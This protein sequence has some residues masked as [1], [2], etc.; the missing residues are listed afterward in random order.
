VIHVHQISKQYGSKVLFESAEAHIGHR[1]RV[2]LIGPNGAGKSTFIRILLGLESPDS[3]SVSRATH[4]AIGHLA[5]EVPKFSN[6]TVLAEVMRMDGR[7]EELLQA[8]QE[9]EAEFAKSESSGSEASGNGVSPDR[10]ERYGRV[11]EELELLDEYRLE[12]RAKEILLGMGFKLSDMDRSLTE[13][14]GG[15]LMRV[16]LS[17]ILLMEPDLL[18]LDE[19]TNHLDLESLLW[20]EEFLK[21]FRGSILVISHDIAFLN[22]IVNEVLEIDQKKLWSYR[23][24][25]DS[26]YQQKEERLAVLRAQYEG[27]QA[28]IAEI[29]K[30]VSRFGAKATKARQAQSKLKQL[31]KMDLIELPDQR[32]QVRFRFPPAPH[33]GKEVVT[34]KNAVL[35]YGE[36]TVFQDLNWVVRRGSRV[37]IVGVNGAG[38]TTLLKL[39]SGQYSP[40]DG[41]VKL[42]HEV[43][44]GYYAQLQAESLD[45]S[46]TVLQELEMT[47][48]HLPVSQ[49][50]AIAGAFLFT[51]DAV[52]KRCAVLSG[53]EK[54]RVAL[55]KLLLS[56]SNFL[57]LDEPTN[58][59]DVES[60]G[61]LLDALQDYEG[62]LCIVSHDRSFVS[63]LVD[64]VLEIVPQE[65]GKGSQVNQL[66]GGYEDYLEKKI[67]ETAQA[68]GL[69]GTGSDT[70]KKKGSGAEGT[71]DQGASEPVRTTPSNNQKR[72]WERER[73]KTESEISKLEQRLGELN[74]LLGDEA[75]YQDKAKSLQLMEEQRKIEAELNSKIARWEELCTLLG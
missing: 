68:V 50:R 25:L 48:P 32:S 14:S 71:G 60:R 49:V 23:G 43:K 35:K 61:V 42:G 69:S 20:L 57:I 74:G 33:S 15:W 63:P 73:D 6:R 56:P 72:S 46:K 10:L 70:G 2:A 29:E 17:R 66:L 65:G 1:S 28:K 44:L 34:V 3:G 59:L 53:G 31:E 27:Q 18:L 67:R 24:N 11:L 12:A 52:E 38:K 45:L 16:A 21:R 7:R 13:F 8:K 37:A 4:L 64:S 51:G 47:A 39:L 55:A 54:A 41:E 58:H 36:K 75:T 22:R 5:Q 19:P 9:L 40:S 62:T 30:F 26:F